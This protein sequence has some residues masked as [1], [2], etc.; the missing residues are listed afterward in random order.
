LE[1]LAD[2][3][4][5]C[6]RELAESLIRDC[7]SEGSIFSYSSFEKTVINGLKKSFPDLDKDLEA[8]TGRIIDLCAIFQKY[9]Y[10]PDFHGSYSIKDVLPVLMPK[11]SYEHLDI[12]DGG[13]AIPSMKFKL[14]LQN[15]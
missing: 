13:M 12:N 14:Q 3:S 4:R 10:H 8:L 1:Y 9:Y 7:G 6:R 2:P 5:D 11:M 15:F